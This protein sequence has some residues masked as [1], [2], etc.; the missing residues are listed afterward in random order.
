L[1]GSL[2]H[3]QT[4]KDSFARDFRLGLENLYFVVF[5]TQL[6]P[7]FAL[8]E[9]IHLAVCKNLALIGVELGLLI[10]AK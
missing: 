5:D 8:F 4:F 6:L 10:G 2:H 7:D 3:F 1:N 9:E